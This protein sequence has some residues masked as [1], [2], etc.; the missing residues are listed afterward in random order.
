[1]SPEKGFIRDL[2][3]WLGRRKEKIGFLRIAKTASDSSGASQETHARPKDNQQ[4]PDG[5]GG[6]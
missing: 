6:I 4:V 3:K 2:A 5:L 1:M